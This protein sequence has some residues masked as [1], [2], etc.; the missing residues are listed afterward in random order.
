MVCPPEHL[1]WFSRAGITQLLAR[2]GLKA[3][4]FQLAL[5]P[6]LKVFARKA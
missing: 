3:E 2:H 5:K 4:K 1:T 6:G